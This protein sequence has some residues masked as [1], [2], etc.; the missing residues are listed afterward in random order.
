MAASLSAQSERKRQSGNRVTLNTYGRAEFVYGQ[1]KVSNH[2]PLSR[3]VGTH[4]FT[5][6]VRVN[7]EGYFELAQLRVCWKRLRTKTRRRDTSAQRV[8]S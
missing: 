5:C 2:E 3:P 4:D 7:G 8:V 1:L 6:N